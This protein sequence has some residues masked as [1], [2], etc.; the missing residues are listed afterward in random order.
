[1]ILLVAGYANDAVQNSAVLP[2]TV[3]DRNHY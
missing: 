1:M 2:Q 3:G